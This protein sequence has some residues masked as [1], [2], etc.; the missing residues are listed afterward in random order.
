M[1]VAQGIAA[2]MDLIA[3]AARVGCALACYCL[4]VPY[5]STRE[6]IFFD[7]KKALGGD[8]GLAGCMPVSAL[9]GTACI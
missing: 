2:F 3:A 8:Q 7:N 6:A 4:V 9:A 5:K 1:S